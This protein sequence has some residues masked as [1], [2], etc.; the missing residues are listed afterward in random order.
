V[1]ELADLSLKRGK[2]VLFQ[3]FNLVLPDPGIYVLSGPTGSGKSLICRLI[4]G[5]L[6]PTSGTVRIDGSPPRKGLAG[7]SSDFYGEA[8]AA[9]TFNETVREYLEA[10]LSVAGVNSVSVAD[11]FGLLDSYLP[12]GINAPV[13]T[14]SSGEF[15]ILQAVLAAAAPGR[16]AILDGHLSVLSED[17]ATYCWQILQ[18]SQVEHEKFIILTANDAHPRLEGESTGFQLAGGLPVRFKD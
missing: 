10:E 13:A 17:A 11:Y 1:I 14:L 8:G 5:L 6:R 15:L 12:G 7:Q 4:A 9:N 16:I 18:S 3:G 2:A